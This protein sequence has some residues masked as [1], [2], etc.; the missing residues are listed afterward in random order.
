MDI[1]L[2]Y[3]QKCDYNC[4]LVAHL[5]V[6]NG[7][8]FE[9]RTVKSAIIIKLHYIFIVFVFLSR[10]ILLLTKLPNNRL[11]L[12]CTLAPHENFFFWNKDQKYDSQLPWMGQGFIPVAWTERR[13]AAIC[14]NL[15]EL[16]SIIDELRTAVLATACTC[17]NIQHS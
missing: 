15:L 6:Y 14:G 11:S 10:I 3:P 4:D 2:G 8:T 1:S 7:S 13:Y 17:T 16:F 9:K 12:G 5:T